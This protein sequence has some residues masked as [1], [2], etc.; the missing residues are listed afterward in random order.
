MIEGD[1]PRVTRQVFQ[2][3]A[4]ACLTTPNDRRHVNALPAIVFFVDFLTKALVS[5]LFLSLRQS[6]GRDE[7]H[8]LTVLTE[9]VAANR[10]IMIDQF[11]RFAAADRDRVESGVLVIVPLGNIRNP[12][13]IGAEFH[14]A[15]VHFAGDEWTK[16]IAF[17][18]DHMQFGV[19]TP[20]VAHT[21]LPRHRKCVRRRGARQ[22]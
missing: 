6:F 16:I 9:I 22:H 17:K 11:A 3:L 8:L 7:C 21:W 14:L 4:L 5:Q 13:A 2:H 19:G 12:L 15:N 20:I 1:V 10:C 18:I